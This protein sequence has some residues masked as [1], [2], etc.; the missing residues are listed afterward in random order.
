MC[1]RL[2]NGSTVVQTS[3]VLPF[4]TNSTSRSSSNR[5][6]RYFS[7]S[8]LPCSGSF[9]DVASLGVGQFVVLAVGAAHGCVGSSRPMRSRIATASDL[10][11]LHASRTAEACAPMAPSAEVR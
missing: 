6:K 3:R 7:G 10:K 5:R 1:L 8:G 4:H 2:W 9:G 11:S